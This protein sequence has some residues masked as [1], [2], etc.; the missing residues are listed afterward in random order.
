[1]RMV[2]VVCSVVLMATAA[3]AK[4][5][6]NQAATDEAV[7]VASWGTSQ[8]IPEPGNA[9]PADDLRDATVRQ[10]FHLSVGGSALRVHL[11]NAFGTEALHFTSVHVAHAVSPASSA[12]DRG[13]DR[14]LTFAGSPD[15]TIPPGAEMVSDPVI[16][17]VAPLSDVT[18]TFHLDAPPVPETGHPGSRATSYSVHGDQVSAADLSDAKHVDH[19]YQVTGIDVQ[20]VP[21]AASV[22]AL[23]DSTTD[24]HGAT[25]NGNDR[26]TDDLAVRLQGSA[27]TREIGVSNQGIG[28]NHLLIDG[29]GPSALARFD[30]DV[31]APAGVRWLIV[32]EGVNDLGGLARDHEVSPAEH[33]GFVQRVIGAYEQ[34]IVRA[35]EH[36]LRVYGATITP[37]VGSEY[38]HPGP[39]SEAD[40]QA[41]NAWIRAEGHFD[42]VIDFDAA[43]RDPQHP[44][45]YL[46]AYD[47]GD[48]LHPSPAG[49]KAMADAIPLSLLTQGAAGN[50]AKAT[51]GSTA[52]AMEF[53]DNPNFT[54]AGVR[55]WT[56]AGG[57]GSDVSLRTSEALNREAVGL[58]ASDGSAAG[59]GNPAAEA[60]REAGTTAEANGDPLK[61]VHE[62]VQ[63]VRLDPS[64]QNYFAW[65]SEL[66][67]HRAVLQAKEVFEQGVKLYPKSS[68]LLT[69]LGAALFAGA[70]YEESAERLC[71]ASDLDPRAPEPYQFMGKIEVVAPHFT[72]CMDARLKRYAEL[73]PNDSLANYFYAMDLWRA[74][75]P[76]PDAE[77]RQKIEALLTKAVT[78]DAKCSDGFL[79]LGNLKSAEKD[80]PAAAGFY[81]KAIASNPES[82]EAHYRLGVAYDRLGKKDKAK[83]EFAAHD[84]INKQQAAE[85]EQERKAVKQFVVDMQG[86]PA[87][88]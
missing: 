22:V 75:G 65:G 2:G 21:G 60:H 61:A 79:Q 82:S 81:E 44:E 56:A 10:V 37:F 34:I 5:E 62:F 70:F 72:S 30:R 31:L 71:E 85:T 1:M 78:I 7:W 63:A 19:W 3:G 55:D 64:E 66:L 42:A 47:C 27:A 58:K 13:S 9:L 18:V 36:G 73:D 87:A 49:Y 17:A 43:V 25:T 80:Y 33:A 15:V 20:A 14:A 12:I 76:S 16:E 51:S 8:Q 48:H 77:M 28:G 46:P 52:Q 40:R 67:V 26:W 38:Y 54:I 69:S 59:I 45:R 4:E 6:P 29:L 88:R 74:Q 24:G 86:K 11:S 41:V 23:G 68:R 83:A 84:A 53:A 50:S 57:H 35:H 39:L 32:Y